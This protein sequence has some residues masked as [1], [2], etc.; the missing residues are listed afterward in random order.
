MKVGDK[1]R[2]TDECKENFLNELSRHDIN[3]HGLEKWVQDLEGE[4]IACSSS[5]YSPKSVRVIF[6]NGKN[7]CNYI[8]DCKCFGL[9]DE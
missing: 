1:V 8:W 4:I 3:S 9:E 2:F 5:I 6:K 7:E